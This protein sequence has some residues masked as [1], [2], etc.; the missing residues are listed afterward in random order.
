MIVG[1]IFEEGGNMRTG[2]KQVARA[3]S[4][5]QAPAHKALLWVSFLLPIA[6]LVLGLVFIAQTSAYERTRGVEYLLVS[7]WGIFFGLIIS[8][9]P[10]IF[11]LSN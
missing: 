7:F 8:L 10:L 2:D 5:A 9:L 3:L 6:G 4:Y 11:L 1:H